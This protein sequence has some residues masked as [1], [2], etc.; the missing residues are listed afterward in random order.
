LTPVLTSG[1]AQLSD[2]LVGAGYEVVINGDPNT[3]A[4][5]NTGLFNQALWSTVLYWRGDQDAG[6]ASDSLT[7]YWPGTFPTVSTVQNFDQSIYGIEFLLTGCGLLALVTAAVY[8][9]RLTTRSQ[10][11]SNEGDI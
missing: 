5:D 2:N 1:G 9:R 7:V 6:T 3:L 11:D 8:R 10:G 4:D